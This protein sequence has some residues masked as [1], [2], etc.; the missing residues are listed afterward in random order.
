MKVRNVIG[1]LLVVLLSTAMIITFMEG[2]VKFR[3]DDDKST[4]YVLN[5]NSRWVVSGRE[6]NSLW[7][8]T[9]KMN[10]QASK[11]VRSQTIEGN[12]TTFTRT[13][14]YIRGPTIVDTYTFDGSLKDVEQF[15][16]SH[17]VQVINASGLI[18]QYEIRDAEYNGTAHAVDDSRFTFG[19]KMKVEWDPTFYNARVYKSGILKVRWR[20]TSDDRSY[21]VR[22][23]DP[24]PPFFVGAN[25]SVEL[26]HK[27][28]NLSYS[29]N[30]SLIDTNYTDVI[31]NQ[32]GN[33]TWNFSE[34]VTRYAIN[35]TGAVTLGYTFNIT[36]NRTIV[37]NLN[38][39][40]NQTKPW[41]QWHCNGTNITTSF[42]NIY[43]IPVN[44]SVYINCTLELLNISQK[45][46]NWSLNLDRAFWDFNYTFE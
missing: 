20:V 2:G 38:M 44:S 19:K 1:Y 39:S 25:V 6:L 3:I 31:M 36:N 32:D 4:F 12:I 5:E 10:R 35:N 27:L 41:Y 46:V 45:Y 9:S 26:N 14:P 34:N 23:F 37:Y 43:V 42:T 29:V 21:R 28:T 8:G 17:T 40:M 11:I 13:T 16:V 22:L 30:F 33:Y 15:P 18:Y 7:D 24:P